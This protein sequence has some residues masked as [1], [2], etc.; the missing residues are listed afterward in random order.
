MEQL[1]DMKIVPISI[2]TIVH[3]AKLEVDTSF[4]PSRRDP[5]DSNYLIPYTDHLFIN[6]FGYHNKV[7]A[8]TKADSYPYAN[9][10]TEYKILSSMTDTADYTKKGSLLMSAQEK[11]SSLVSLAMQHAQPTLQ[12]AIGIPSCPCDFNWDSQQVSSQYESDRQTYDWLSENKT[13]LKFIPASIE[14]VI[15]GYAHVEFTYLGKPQYVP[16]SASPDYKPP[17]LDATA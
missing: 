7:Q 17:K 4:Q 3:H 10:T 16:P 8:N 14:Y 11:T 6:T 2:E 15:K 5:M 13:K 1:L 12:S 9:S